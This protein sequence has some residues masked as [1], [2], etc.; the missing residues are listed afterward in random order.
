M[1]NWENV[2]DRAVRCVNNPIINP[3][4]NNLWESELVYNP[5]ALKVE[6]T[7]F[8][9][10]RAMGD[11]HIARFGL[12]YSKNGINFE[13]LDFPIMQPTEHYELPHEIT[14]KRERERGGIEDPRATIIGDTIY[15]YYTSF[16]KKCHI[17]MASMKIENFA[18]LVQNSKENVNDY[19]KKWNEAWER[20]GLVFPEQFENDN[21]F[22]RNAVLHK[23]KKDL[24]VLLYRVD[25][26]NINYSFASTP[27]GPWQY[28]NNSLIEKDL[29]WE[30]ERIG[31]STPSI[32]IEDRGKKFSLF[33]YHGV[34]SVGAG[35]ERRYHLGAFLLESNLEK[36]EL[37]IHKLLEPVMSPKTSYEVNSKWLNSCGV[38]AIFSCGVIL[39]NNDIFIY[40]GAGDSV[41]CLAKVTVDDI[42]KMKTK[43]SVI[44]I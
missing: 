15:L 27:V 16:H 41:I 24:F 43:M 29:S 31:I 34:E 18:K 20:H 6:D 40:Y 19:S 17:A 23:L 2:S 10:Y 44:K 13:R 1:T 3:K 8:L 38:E 30:T 37:Q 4:T 9:I 26:G 32:E 21:I 33:F 22:S 42:L 39:F 25:K 5:A 7:I 36:D 35:V 14:L 11:D 12:A 28:K